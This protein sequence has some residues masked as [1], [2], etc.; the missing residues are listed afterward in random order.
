MLI[1]DGHLDLAFNALHN[2]RDLTQNVQTLRER[3]DIDR[4]G[5]GPQ[6]AHP[7]AMGKEASVGDVGVATVALPELR[8]AQVGVVMS[9]IMARVQMPAGAWCEATDRMV[10]PGGFRTSSGSARACR[11]HRPE[12]R[13]RWTARR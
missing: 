6:N 1:V 11:D 2:R 7:D 4:D 5:V 12:C 8:A 13:G 10:Q 9:T 3:E